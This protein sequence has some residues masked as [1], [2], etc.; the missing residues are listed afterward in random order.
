MVGGVKA[1]YA[2]L[3]ALVLGVG[4]GEDTGGHTS[5]RQASPLAEMLPPI[6]PLGIVAMG[7]MGS[8]NLGKREAVVAATPRAEER[9]ASAS[10]MKSKSDVSQGILQPDNARGNEETEIPSPSA[11]KIV[12][13]RSVKPPVTPEKEGVKTHGLTN[14]DAVRIL[15]TVPGVKRVLPILSQPKNVKHGRREVDCQLI[16]TY[17][18]YPDFTQSKIVAGQ[19]LNE[20]EENGKAASCVIAL[21]LA[22]RLFPGHNPL[23]EKVVVRGYESS[24]VFQVKGILQEPSANVYIPLSTFKALYDTGNIDRSTGNL[25]IEVVELTEIRV[26]FESVKEV[27][28]AL[29]LLRNCLNKSRKGKAD[30]KI[31]TPLFKK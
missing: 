27:V 16:G 1:L 30:Y 17:P 19:F 11:V 26:E 15:K 5:R 8:M 25:S 20:A 12:I 21:E 13:I 2:V 31:H 22:E 23:M 14:S 10:S 24:Q 29:P 4:C 6:G 9:G 3:L 18:Y 7:V 28:P